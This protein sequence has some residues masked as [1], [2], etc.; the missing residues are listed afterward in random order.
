VFGTPVRRSEDPALLRGLGRYVAD[1]EIPGCLWVSYVISTVAH[2]RLIGIDASRA[3]SGSG[4]MDVITAEDLDIGPLPL[5]N[6]RYPEAMARP[7]LASKVVRFVGEAVAAVVAETAEAA[8]DAL[9]GIEVEYEPLP[10]VVDPLDALS[11]QVLLYPDHGSNV[12]IRAAGGTEDANPGASE[13]VIRASFDSHRIAPCPLE[14]R[15]A[16]SRWEPDGRL[17]HWSS[18]QGA[19]PV[20]RLLCGIHG[21]D[22]QQVRVIVPEV[23]GSFGAKSRPYPEEV[24]LPWLAARTGRPVKWVSNRSE[25][26]VGLGHSR[27]Q[28]QEIELGGRRD[29]TIE[30]LR[31][32]ILADAGAYPAVAPLLASGNTGVLVGGAYRIP[33]VAWES[34]AVVTNTTPTTAYRG[35]GRPEAAA[36]IE[37]AV[38][39]FSVEIGLDP[40]EVRRRNFIP[41]TAFPYRSATGLVYDSGNYEAVLDVALAA[42][43][44]DE[45]RTEQV[46]SREDGRPLLGVGLATFVDRTAGVPGGEYGA[47]ELTADG[48]ALV[49]TGSTP[50]GQGHRTSWAMLVAERTGIPFERIEVIYGDTDLVPRGDLTGGSRSVQKAGAAVVVATEELVVQAKQIAAELLEAAVDDVVLDVDA[51]GRFHVAGTPSISV[52]WRQVAHTAAER[53]TPGLKCEADVDGDPTCPFGAYVAVVEVDPETGYVTPTRMV[54]VDDAG[55]ILNPLIAEGQVHGGVAQGIGQA[56]F[57]QFSYDPGGNPLTGTFADYAVPSAMELPSFESSFF[58]TPSP[59]NVLGAKGLAESGTIGAPPA[60]QNAVIDALQHL[61]VRHIDMP[62]TPE[63]V[64]SAITRASSRTQDAP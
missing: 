55:R 46:T 35:A 57:E 12:V 64:R 21:L 10:A 52:D 24:L 19:H 47:V 41:P 51:G 22:P 23:G 63:R 11:D 59:N 30:A 26:M 17:T 50:Y 39:L 48:G 27:A 45:L 34:V 2:A 31:V 54:T 43:G 61:G 6:P 16:A 53:E 25:D 36:V 7:L 49:R 20:Q 32:R 58:E 9:E 42:A 13:V 14:T 29:G 62:C 56:L 15:A 4:V 3:A 44:Y 5:I 28:R 1:L 40:A 33:A 60:T 8:A 38:D 37:R 18:C